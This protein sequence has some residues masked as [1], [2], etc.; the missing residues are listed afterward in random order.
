[1]N[2]GK[3]QFELEN[4]IQTVDADSVYMHDREYEE[5]MLKQKPWTKS[6]HYFTKCKISAVALIKM[7]IHARSGGD[8]EVMGMLQGRIDGDTIIVMDAFAIPAEGIETRVDPGAEG[9]AYIISYVE[10][11][12]W[13]G[14]P[15]KA[16][17]W[18]HSHPGYGCWLS[19]IDV[20][21]QDLHQEHE[22]YPWL[23]IVVDPKR[24][25]SAGK[26][27]IGAFRTYPKHYTPPE[28]T[29]QEWQP[30]PQDKIE[31]FGTHHSQYYSLE[32]SY[33]K[34]SADSVL[35]DLLW[36]KYWVNTLSSSSLLVNR[37]YSAGQMADFARKLEEV[38][39]KL[40]ARSSRGA[41]YFQIKSKGDVALEQLNR[42]CSQNTIDHLGGAM[43][44]IAKH[45]VFNHACRY[46]H[47]DGEADQGS[48]SEAQSVGMDIS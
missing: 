39:A 12:E 24:T 13:V 4:N 2:L 18:Y 17:G 7:V 26:V 38:D 19:G 34:S 15:E 21:T 46:G 3:A 8:I 14:R 28:T 25:M 29:E 31:D 33:F 30:I 32:V 9:M 27:E 35:L 23:A 37:V 40:S 44:L 43:A 10:S 1:M 47:K 16:L 6:F 11:Q 41:G 22:D 45:H 48:T 36:E 42:D 20:A 5:K